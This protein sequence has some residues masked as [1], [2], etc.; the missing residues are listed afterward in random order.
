[1][2]GGFF[3]PSLFFG[4]WPGMVAAPARALFVGVAYAVEVKRGRNDHR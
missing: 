4:F 1:M 2:D 3:L